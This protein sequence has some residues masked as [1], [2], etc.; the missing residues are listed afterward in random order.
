[1]KNDDEELI[2]TKTQIIIIDIIICIGLVLGMV[3]I[4]F[5]IPF[6]IRLFFVIVL[7]DLIVLIIFGTYNTFKNK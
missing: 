1:M 4:L 3:G 2:L 5:S 6:Y 7:L